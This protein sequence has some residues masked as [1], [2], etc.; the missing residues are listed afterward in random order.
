MNMWHERFK[1][2]EYVY[3]KEASE[4]VRIAA[5]KLRKE[6]RV[7]SI[8]EGEGR[9]AVFLAENG[10]HVTT[11]DYALSG[12]E[13]TKKLALERGVVVEAEFCDL[14]EAEWTEDKWDAVIHVFGHFPVP[15]F[16]KTMEGIKKSLKPGGL[17]VSELYS[18]EQIHFK[19]GGPRD[20]ELLYTPIQMLNTFQDWYIHHFYTGE[21]KRNE[22]KLH[23]G[24]SH[25]IQ[26]IFQK[27]TK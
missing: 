5:E 23:Q 22:G 11:W 17:Y 21:A 10:L 2:E 9:N 16:E 27:P 24:T 6:S 20:I 14:A 25:V 26:S 3:G 13:K 1:E 12:I 19:S 18:T 15:V 4:I 8:A 7:L